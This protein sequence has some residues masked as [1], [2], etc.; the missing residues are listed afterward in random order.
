MII[1]KIK[2]IK[3]FFNFYGCWFT[4]KGKNKFDLLFRVEESCWRKLAGDLKDEIFLYTL[5]ILHKH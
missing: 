1:K 4:V 5:K 3:K 2:T